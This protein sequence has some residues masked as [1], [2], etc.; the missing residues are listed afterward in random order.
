[1]K[2]QV[3]V[4]SLGVAL[5]GIIV[6]TSEKTA[7]AEGEKRVLPIFQVDP[8]FP[9]MPD[10]MELGGVGGVNADSHGNVW[11]FQRPHT[12]EDGNSMDN[13]YK[14]AP[15]VLEF[16]E[17]GTYIQGWGGPSWLRWRCVE[18]SIQR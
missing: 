8:N 6:G 3:L 5:I 12:I 1:M 14:I 13:G 16:D 4:A 9:T 7:I 17:R 15:P 18:N 10:H 2:S 11:V